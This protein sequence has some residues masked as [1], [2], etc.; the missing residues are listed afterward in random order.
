MPPRRGS[1]FPRPLAP[2][3]GLNPFSIHT[4]SVKKTGPNLPYR[5]VAGVTPFAGRWVV[6]TGRAGGSNFA[7]QHP[8]IFDTF[9]DVLAER[10]PYEKAVVNAPVGY[11]ARIGDPPRTCDVMAR[12]AL[13]HRALTFAPAP[14]LSVLE[15]SE[16]YRNARLGAAAASRLLAMREV[17][18]NVPNYRQRTVFSGHPEL[19]FM[20][21]NQEQPMTFSKYSDEGIAERRALLEKRIPYLAP[22]IDEADPSIPTPVVLDAIALLWTARRVLAKAARR[23]PAELEWDADGRRMEWVF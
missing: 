5:L 3:G 16:D 23:L 10:P 2:T 14:P 6:V 15:W 20:G 11:Q 22:A 1:R 21:L 18:L 13:G 7:V 19:S 4:Q 9:A 12:N 8:L 17:M